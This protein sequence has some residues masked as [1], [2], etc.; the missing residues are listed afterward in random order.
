MDYS[1]IAT[2]VPQ[3]LRR[4]LADCDTVAILSPLDKGR[5]NMCG[6]EP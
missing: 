5:L 2:A 1:S 4:K 6:R 3:S